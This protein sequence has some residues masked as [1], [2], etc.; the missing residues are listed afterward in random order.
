MKSDAPILSRVSIYVIFLFASQNCPPSR[1]K[2]KE[3]NFLVTFATFPIAF[4]RK[5]SLWERKKKR[6]GE[7]FKEVVSTYKGDLLVLF[8]SFKVE[9]RGSCAA[10]SI[11]IPLYFR[12][13]VRGARWLSRNI[14]NMRSKG[15]RI[16]IQYPPFS[17]V[18]SIRHWMVDIDTSN[19]VET[20]LWTFTQALR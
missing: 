2:E 11:S 20:F 14:S 19:E 16:P 3:D 7:S 12:H 6:E 8:S 9:V 17:V 10:R 13:T 4:L 1:E 15:G 5:F 18:P